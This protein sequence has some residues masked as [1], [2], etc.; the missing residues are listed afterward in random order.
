MLYW[1]WCDFKYDA[2]GEN[3]QL[4]ARGLMFFCYDTHISIMISMPAALRNLTH[5]EPVPV[6]FQEQNLVFCYHEYVSYSTVSKQHWRI[7]RKHT[8]LSGHTNVD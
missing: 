7:V 1:A 4:R 3:Y 5:W 6:R 8:H 2:S